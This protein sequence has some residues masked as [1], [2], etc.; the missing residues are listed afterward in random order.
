M[1]VVLLLDDVLLDDALL[2]LDDVLL[3][4]VLPELDDVPV[5]DV[6]GVVLAG[7]SDDS[8]S[9]KE[10]KSITSDFLSLFELLELLDC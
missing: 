10:S 4:D 5:D 3:D 1:D 2:E 6:E 7:L 9:H 8:S